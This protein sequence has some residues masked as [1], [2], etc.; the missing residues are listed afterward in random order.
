M[1]GAAFP[2]AP[3]KVMP[4]R[5]LAILKSPAEG[6]IALFAVAFT[7]MAG[8]LASD[9]GDG[10]VSRYVASG[11]VSVLGLAIIYGIKFLIE[12]NKVAAARHHDNTEAGTKSQEIHV[13]E[14][15]D[16]LAA[17]NK[18][19]EQVTASFK[20]IIAQQ[21]ESFMQLQEAQR[22]DFETQIKEV[23]EEKHNNGRV[24]QAWLLRFVTLCTRAE[25]ANCDPSILFAPPLN[26]PRLREGIDEDE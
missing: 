19:I 7:T 25:M 26:K 2:N 21:R 24:A 17:Q 5:F 9:S 8:G 3:R 13:T 11:V 20:E 4:E 22:K 23:R 16:F 6:I 10:N 1:N 14:R 18:A 12:R 15:R